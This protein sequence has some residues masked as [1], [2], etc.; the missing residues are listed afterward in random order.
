MLDLHAGLPFYA[1][2]FARRGSGRLDTAL[3]PLRVWRATV[4]TVL[5]VIS[6][7][8]DDPVGL[9]LIDQVAMLGIVFGNGNFFARGGAVACQPPALGH[10]VG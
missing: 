6:V 8:G 1:R 5:V 2:L 4:L 7:G 10:G 3:E 9:F